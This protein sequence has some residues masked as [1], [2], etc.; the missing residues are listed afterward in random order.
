M[1]TT[2]AELWIVRQR[3]LEPGR[4]G[5]RG[6]WWHQTYVCVASS[7]EDAIARVMADHHNPP[8]GSEWTAWA[9]DDGWTYL[10]LEKAQGSPTKGAA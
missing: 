9:E 4:A 10:R 3:Y 6:Q 5:R 2:G 8:S 1:G 7:K